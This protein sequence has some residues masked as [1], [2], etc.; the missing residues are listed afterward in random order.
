M[1][2]MRS[3]AWKR[4]FYLGVDCLT[5]ENCYLKLMMKYVHYNIGAEYIVSI[6]QRFCIDSNAAGLLIKDRIKTGESLLEAL[7]IVSTDRQK[8]LDKN[9]KTSKYALYTLEG[10]TMTLCE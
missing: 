10:K 8:P 4:I 1:K 3:M 9:R 6:L 5:K 7:D 2:Y